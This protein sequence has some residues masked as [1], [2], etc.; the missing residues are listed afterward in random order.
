M[1]TRRYAAKIFHDLPFLCNN[2]VKNCND[3]KKNFT[4]ILQKKLAK[5]YKKIF[6]KNM[7]QY[8][9]T[10]TLKFFQR[11]RQQK[12]LP[13]QWKLWRNHRNNF[14]RRNFG[15]M[16]AFD[17]LLFFLASQKHSNFRRHARTYH[18]FSSTPKMNMYTFAHS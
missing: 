11:L 9:A 12:L 16:L 2:C 1:P 5:K 7:W 8:C 4:K 6:T 3:Y 18:L 10:T 13:P 15:A 14:F 17:I